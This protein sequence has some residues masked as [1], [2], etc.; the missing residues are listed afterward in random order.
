MT[1]TAAT[2]ATP[3][4]AKENVWKYPRPPALEPSTRHLRVVLPDGRE[5]A[6]TRSALRVLETSHPP[7][8]YIPLDDCH[9]ELLAPSAAP[10][11]FCE[12]ERGVYVQWKG[13]ADYLDVGDVRARAWTYRNPTDAFSGIK[14][15]VAF[16]SSPF[17][18]FVDGE[19]VQAQPGSFYGGW[20]TSDLEGPFKGAPGTMGW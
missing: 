11:T 17:E 10:Q 19:R 6:S 20:I 9:R 2:A 7:T 3:P 12:G 1:A 16:Y 18:C 4:R 14:D 8:Y 13:K 15:H 5:V